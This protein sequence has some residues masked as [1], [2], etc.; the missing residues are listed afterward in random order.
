[1][2]F[3]HGIYSGK[4]LGENASRVSSIMGS[5]ATSSRSRGWSRFYVDVPSVI[6]VYCARAMHTESVWTN[7]T[8][9][10]VFDDYF[11]LTLTGDGG[12]KVTTAV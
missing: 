9:P 10:F 2:A 11:Y 6:D 1:M 5:S 4:F 3:P 12:G 7:E 8:V